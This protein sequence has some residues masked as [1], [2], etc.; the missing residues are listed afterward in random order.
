MRPNG[1]LKVIQYLIEF[2]HRHIC[3]MISELQ[4][5]NPERR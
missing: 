1:C 3:V 2:A 4:E 5:I